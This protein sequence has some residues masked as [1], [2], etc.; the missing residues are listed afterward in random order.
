MCKPFKTIL[1]HRRIRSLPHC[2]CCSFPGIAWP[3]VA[4]NIDSLPVLFQVYVSILTSKLTRPWSTVPIWRP[5]YKT[6]LKLSMSEPDEIQHE[7][8]LLKMVVIYFSLVHRH[9]N[10]SSWCKLVLCSGP[11]R[12]CC[13]SGT[14][15]H[16][17]EPVLWPSKPKELVPG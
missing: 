12:C 8:L 10:P 13:Y 17:W 15:F 2:G 7:P 1:F 16:G 6:L 14:S 11:A 5:L 9:D 3:T 4:D